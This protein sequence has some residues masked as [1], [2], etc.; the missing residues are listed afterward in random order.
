MKEVPAFGEAKLKRQNNKSTWSFLTLELTLPTNL[1]LASHEQGSSL[2]TWHATLSLQSLREL[3]SYDLIHARLTRA[4]LTSFSHELS[5]R[6]SCIPA[7]S[8]TNYAYMRTFFFQVEF[9]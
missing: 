3:S 2:Q 6:T 5:L 4:P 9:I 8:S 1:A 7:R